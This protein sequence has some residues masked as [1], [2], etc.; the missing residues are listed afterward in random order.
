MYVQCTSL[1]TG[2]FL[3]H[4][5]FYNADTTT[6]IRKH[7]HV[8]M[9]LYTLRMQG[10]CI[11]IYRQVPALSN[12]WHICSAS[13]QSTYLEVD[14]IEDLDPGISLLYTPDNNISKSCTCTILSLSSPDHQ[15]ETLWLELCCFVCV[16]RPQPAELPR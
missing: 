9:M 1:P 8:N 14:E 7:L 15:V 3:Q 2:N 12:L 5:R 4:K 13:F 10:N 16:I 11:N 6:Y